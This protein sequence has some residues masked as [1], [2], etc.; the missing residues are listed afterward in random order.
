[1]TRRCTTVPE[2]VRALAAGAPVVIYIVPGWLGS[3]GLRQN[4]VRRIM[5]GA[6]AWWAPVHV[7]WAWL[8]EDEDGNTETA[9]RVWPCTMDHP[10]RLQCR[11]GRVFHVN[12]L[13][14]RRRS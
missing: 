1:V 10:P 13:A 12:A 6:A 9:F 11:D 3:T 8:R 14:G 7:R 4:T 5:Y 2:V